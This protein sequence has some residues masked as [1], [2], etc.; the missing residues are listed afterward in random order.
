M[1]SVDP[2]SEFLDHLSPLEVLLV[3]FLSDSPG[4]MAP[5]LVRLMPIQGLSVDKYLVNQRL[6]YPR[7]LFQWDQAT[8]PK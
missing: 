3:R 4:A 1:T 2:A 5:E 8:P 7:D 6:H